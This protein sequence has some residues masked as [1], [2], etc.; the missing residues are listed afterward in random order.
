MTFDRMMIYL[1][2]REQEEALGWRCVV[3]APWFI[4][5]DWIGDPVVSIKGDEVRIVAILAKTP[6]AGA[7]GRLIDGILAAGLKP[8]VVEPVFMTMPA[9]MERWGWRRRN[10]GQD[11]E[12]YRTFYEPTAQWLKQRNKR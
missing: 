11:F 10:I 3:D 4:K 12:P 7:F 6:G 9:I 5:D 8:I 1:S 2:M